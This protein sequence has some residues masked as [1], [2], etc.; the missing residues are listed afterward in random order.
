MLTLV[1]QFSMTNADFSTILR[2]AFI[3][4]NVPNNSNYTTQA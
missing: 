4:L 3:Y 1:R 2:E